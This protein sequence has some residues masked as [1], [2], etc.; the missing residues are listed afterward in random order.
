MNIR[1]AV[2]PVMNPLK[3]SVAYFVVAIA[4][5][6]GMM[7]ARS[8]SAQNASQV[9]IPFAFSA[10][11]QA[12]PAGHYRVVR[13]SDNYVTVVST[14][15]GI[16]AGLMVRSTRTLAPTVKNSLLFLHDDRGYHLLTVRFAQGRMGVQT[17]MAVQPKPERELAKATTGTPTEVGMN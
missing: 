8:A 14:E 13:E 11:H 16:T 10:N 17:D 1:A 15:T 3:A 5:M 4:V 7:N 12:F 2:S 6:L 9:T